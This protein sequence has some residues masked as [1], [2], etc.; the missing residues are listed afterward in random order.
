M[1]LRVAGQADDVQGDLDEVRVE[2]G[3]VDLEGRRAG[4]Q[5]GVV[6][7]VGETEDRLAARMRHFADEPDFAVGLAL[8]PLEVIGEPPVDDLAGQFMECR[9]LRW[10]GRE[11]RPKDASFIREVRRAS[12]AAAA[13]PGGDG[14]LLEQPPQ[15][16]RLVG[17][18]SEIV[19]QQVVPGCQM[20]DG[21]AEFRDPDLAGEAALARIAA[22]KPS[23]DPCLGRIARGV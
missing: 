21:L 16:V 7:A 9:P 6:L 8:V 20:G 15:A 23:Q 10:L 17:S 13:D 22:M 19:A 2:G 18:G 4:W 11:R 3:P 5:V 12:R 14:I 1:V